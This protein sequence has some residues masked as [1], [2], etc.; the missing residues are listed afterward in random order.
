MADDDFEIGTLLASTVRAVQDAQ[1]N[2]EREYLS[3]LLEYGLEEVRQRTGNR[4]VT[5]LRLREVSFEMARQVPDPSN[6][7]AVVETTATVRAPLLSLVQMPAIGIGEATI[8]LDLDV[9]TDVQESQ[10]APAAPVRPRAALTDRV[11]TAPTRPLP[12]LKGSVGSGAISRKKRSHGKLSVTL[13]LRTTHDDDLHSRI[14]R[15]VGEG[16]S[17]TVDVPERTR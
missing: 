7:G 12:V 1:V 4:E 3:F 10:Q 9:Q 16:L 13:T 2:A 17:A 15:L 14:V 5:R 11:L 6:P 8:T